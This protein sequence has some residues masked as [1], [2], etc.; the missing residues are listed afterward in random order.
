MQE[1]KY[2]YTYVLIG[3]DNRLYIGV[4][5]CN[6]L[7]KNDPYMGSF[8][9][10]TFKPIAKHILG[11][12]STRGEAVAHEISL[13]NEFNVGV[14]PQFANKCKQ[15]SIGFDTAGIKLTLE[16]KAKMSIAQRGRVITAEHRAKIS[17]AKIGT[18]GKMRALE[19]KAKMSTSGIGRVLTTEHKLKIAVANTGKV[20]SAKTKAKL[21]AA[22]ADKSVYLWINI[23][24]T[25]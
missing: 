4:R 9:D 20:T 12:W 15:S 25:Q 5:S 19:T 23:K 2:H 8:T 18:K 22:T 21:S 6:C 24:L 7:P 16:H 17:L 13:H 11:L 10:K 14:N 3:A 1:K